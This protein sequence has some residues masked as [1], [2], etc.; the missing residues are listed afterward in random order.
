[1]IQFLPVHLGRLAGIHELV[2]GVDMPTEY[3]SAAAATEPR[4]A[5]SSISVVPMLG[6]MLPRK[7]I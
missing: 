2:L 3:S 7:E 4:S 1:M 6:G 5:H